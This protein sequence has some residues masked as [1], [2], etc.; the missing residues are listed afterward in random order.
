[1]SISINWSELIRDRKR[2]I[3]TDNKLCGNMIRNDDKNIII[4]KGPMRQ[5]IYRIPKSST[6]AYNGAELRLTI[7]Y[8]EFDINFTTSE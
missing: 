4:E 3:I 8:D 5:R 6:G 2:I 7:S 1:M